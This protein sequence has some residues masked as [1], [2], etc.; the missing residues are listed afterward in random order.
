MRANPIAPSIFFLLLL[1]GCAS[2]QSI[3]GKWSARLD[4]QGLSGELITDFRADGTIHASMISDQGVN[5]I[6]TYTYVR[7]GNKITSTLTDAQVSGPIVDSNPEYKKQIESRVAASRGR[8]E[9][10]TFTIVGD[11]MHQTTSKGKRGK[12]TRMK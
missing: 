12:M 4:E 8:T 7:S 9:T 11:T 2:E 5:V 10:V 3:L 6:I 1:S